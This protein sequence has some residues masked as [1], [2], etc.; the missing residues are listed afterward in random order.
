MKDGF[1][2]QEADPLALYDR[3]VNRF[4]AGFIGTPPMNFFEGRIAADA[5]GTL[6]F[7]GAAGL[8][9]PVPAHRAPALQAHRGQPVTLGLR[10]EDIGSALAE[11]QPGAPR[12]SAR[13]HVVEPMGAESYVHMAAG[14][15]VCV[16][17]V[18][19]HRTFRV[20][21]TATPAVCIDKAHFFDAQTERRI[22]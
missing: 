17:R 18:D 9:L 7:L 1:I 19:A 6:E 2:Q 16:S 8:R 15:S 20:G 14:G 11:Q 4:V 13:V 22:A 21:E 12:L 5:D 10:P 3:P